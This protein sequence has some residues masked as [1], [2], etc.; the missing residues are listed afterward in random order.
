MRGLSGQ[1]DRARLR[2]TLTGRV[3]RGFQV[4][5]EYN[6][7]S[8]D[9]SP[10]ANLHLLSETGRRPAVILGTSSDR[11]GTP[12]G[13]SY[14]VTVSKDLEEWSGLPLAPYGGISYGTFDDRIRWIG[15][16]RLSFTP[17]VSSLVIFD[18]V[19]VHPTLTYRR[20]EHSISG[21][22]VGGKDPGIS[23]SISF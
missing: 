17:R 18:G 16:F 12:H 14:Y 23:Y 19:R 8:R 21:I 7:L 20:G 15:G 1:I 11:I 4:G 9:V 22:L 3:F 5:V 13:Q 2:T 10:L 6:P